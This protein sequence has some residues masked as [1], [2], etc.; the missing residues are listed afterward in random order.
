MTDDKTIFAVKIKGSRLQRELWTM[1]KILVVLA[2]L[3][4][5]FAFV[6]VQFCQKDFPRK[7]WQECLRVGYTE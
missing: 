7:S 1:L 3:G 2:M 6:Q 4:F 5:V